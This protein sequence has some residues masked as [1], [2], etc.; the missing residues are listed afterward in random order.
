MIGKI[1]EIQ[2]D[3]EIRE[4]K[5]GDSI[6][7]TRDLDSISDSGSVSLPYNKDFFNLPLFTPITIYAGE[8]S[9]SYY[10]K[11]DLIKVF[12]G[13][14]TNIRVTRS[15]TSPSITIEFADKVYWFNFNEPIRTPQSLNLPLFNFEGAT[16]IYD[17]VRLLKQIFMES[18]LTIPFE[19]DVKVEENLM[20]PLSGDKNVYNILQHIKQKSV[21]YII[22]N[23]WDNKLVFKTPDYI[24]YLQKG[25]EEVYSFDISNIIN[26]LNVSSTT[27]LVNVVVYVGQGGRKGVAVDWASLVE[28]KKLREVRFYA[29]WTSN[30]EEL[31]RL[32]RNKLL[33]L[34]RNNNI[35]FNIPVNNTT[36]KFLPGML[37]S[38]NDGDIFSGEVF[39]VKSLS[40]T[41]SKNDVSCNVNV[42]SSFITTLPENFVIKDYNITDISSF[43]ERSEKF[44]HDLAQVY[45]Y[46]D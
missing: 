42:Y 29:Q 33:E 15:K 1:V 32:A 19:M 4:F 45:D 41:I 17:F 24:Q 10:T 2:V 28:G 34:L 44:I 11:D 22:Y 37:V 16:N 7:F 21:V 25:E 40:Y 12:D 36:L 30:I 31:E 46:E 8:V 3:G 27:S 26:T 35:S 13:Y 23:P 39:I 6:T 5:L 14:I 18:N 43:R 20:V 38:I 9:S